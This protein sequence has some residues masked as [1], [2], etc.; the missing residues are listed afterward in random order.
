MVSAVVTGEAGWIGANDITRECNL[1]VP[2]CRFVWD[3][4][5]PFL[6]EQ[7]IPM[8]PD[9]FN[10]NEDCVAIDGRV[11]DRMNDAPCLGTLPY[12][13]ETEVGL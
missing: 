9:D 4:G 6:Y 7:W 12:V 2:G 1:Q 10:G 3:S 13:C 8:N 5:E 11:E